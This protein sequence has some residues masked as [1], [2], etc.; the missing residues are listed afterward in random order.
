VKQTIISYITDEILGE[1]APPDLVD[2]TPLL[3]SGMLD[4]LCVEQL[5]VFLE[6]ELGVEF[7]ESDYTAENFETIN[8]MVDL[9]HR[10]LGEGSMDG[11]ASR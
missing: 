7:D 4:S 8:A 6:E 10:K 9:L 5:L 1:D 2:D 3:S 11:A